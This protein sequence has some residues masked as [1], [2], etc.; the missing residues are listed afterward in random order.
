[1][2][3]VLSFLGIIVLGTVL[4]A[5]PFAVKSGKS[6]GF[7]D[8][9]FMATSAVCVTGLSVIDI[10]SQFTVYG[11][12]VMAF[13]MEV[14]GLSI[15][16]IA[17]FFFT[18]NGAKIGISSRFLLKESLNQNTGSGLVALVRKIV[19]IS[20][21]VQLVC[22]GINLIE[23]VNYYPS[24]SQALGVS[25]FHSASAFNNA[26]FDVFGSDS[27]IPFKDN[28]LLNSTTI[29]MIVVGSIGFVVIDDVFRKKF[30]WKKFS[31]HTKLTIIITL[32]LIAFGTLFIKVAVKDDSFS[33]MQAL[34][35]AVTSRTA[36]FSTYDLSA[37]NQYPA[38][39]CVF[40]ILMFIG[41]SPCSTGGGIKTTTFAVVLLSIFYFGFGKN[42]KAFKRRLSKDQIYKAFVLVSMGII[43]IFLGT[44][45][46]SLLQPGMVHA[47]GTAVGINEILFEVTSAF[48]TTGLSMG[49]TT[50]LSGVCRVIL[51]VIMF[52]GRLGPLTVIGILNKNWL[53]NS[54]EQINLIEEKVIIG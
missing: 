11:K 14:G 9:L 25:L 23:L 16:T 36:G 39:Y 27:M 32:F 5:M 51:C 28:I 40:V 49:I 34:F 52:L 50:C 4:L 45:L 33:W 12:V 21:S 7:V 10:S 43:M 48:T 6:I 19:L 2:C 53:G 37:L 41:A 3:I 8:S 54:N 17:V 24:F 30:A 35:G 38:A 18:I 22:A 26:G 20:F 44:F 13:L 1:M 31:L 15:I 29:F 46:V 42:A 47:D